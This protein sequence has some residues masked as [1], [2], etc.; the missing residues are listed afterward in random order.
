MYTRYWLKVGGAA[1]VAIAAGIALVAFT[2]P[3]ALT[4]VGIL[5]QS[6]PAM[7]RISKLDVHWTQV[8]S[9]PSNAITPQ[10][11]WGTLVASQSLAPGTVLTS[12]DF[13]TPQAQGLKPGEVQWLVPVSAASSGLPAVGQRVDVWANNNGTFQA[14]ADGVRV[15]ALYSGNGGPLV[16]A[17][18]TDPNASGPG[19]VALAVPTSS[20]ATLLDVKSPYLIVDPNQSEFHLANATTPSGASTP[21]QS[22]QTALHHKSTPSLPSSK[23][24]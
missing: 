13:S 14:M 18:S 10:M 9:P 1:G 24:G 17:S 19:M 2:R 6:V 23:G 22:A 7:H 3:P 11:T 16:S 15:I 4:T 12:A 21:S 20:I 5:T 8:A